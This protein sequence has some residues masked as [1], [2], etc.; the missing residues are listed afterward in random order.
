MANV[1]GTSLDDFIHRNGDGAVQPGGTNEVIGVTT[2]ADTIDGGLGDDTI[3]ADD[4]DDSILG[5]SGN[6]TMFGGAGN[7]TLD[8][9]SSV[10]SMSGGLGNDTYILSQVGDVAVEA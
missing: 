8:G 6:D 5:G 4:G 7:D 2:G 3:Y 10:D 9:G 1:V